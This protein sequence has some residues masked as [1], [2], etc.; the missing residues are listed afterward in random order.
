MFK[1]EILTFNSEDYVV[2]LT[3][4]AMLEIEDRQRNISRKTAQDEEAIE[5]LSQLSDISKMQEELDKI[6]NMKDGKAKENKIIE[7]NKKYLPLTLK[8]SSSDVLNSSIDPFE[9]VYIL[10]KN[11]PKNKPLTKEDYENGLFEL[12][13]KM[14]LVE[15]EIKFQEMYNKVFREIE[16]VKQTLQDHQAKQEQE[17]II[18]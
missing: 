8:M 17:E 3:R 12:E 2:T 13:E 9:L 11:Y 18:N 15:L 16:F 1:K 4:K 5:V 14:G 7:Y 10:I 6:N